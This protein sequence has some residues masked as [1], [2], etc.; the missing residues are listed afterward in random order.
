LEEARQLNPHF[1]SNV[2][3]IEVW[4]D[5]MR[6]NY[7]RSRVLLDEIESIDDQYKGPYVQSVLDQRFEVLK[8]VSGTEPI[9]IECTELPLL[10]VVEHAYYVELTHE[11]IDVLAEHGG[12]VFCL[13]TLGQ[14]DNVPG[15]LNE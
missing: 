15:L 4:T 13:A 3:D 1:G 10:N 7:E 5:T 9:D 6:A 12:F 11:Q 8:T 14:K 2:N